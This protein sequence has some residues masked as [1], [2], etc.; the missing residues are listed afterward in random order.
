M[1]VFSLNFY[2]YFSAADASTFATKPRHCSLVDIDG[3]KYL[4][5]NISVSFRRGLT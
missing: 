1:S 5:L 3:G 2:S 4:H